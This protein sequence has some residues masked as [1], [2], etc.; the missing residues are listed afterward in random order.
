MMNQR[1][2]RT[3]PA[4]RRINAAF[5]QIATR[6]RGETHTDASLFGM[7]AH[8]I[9]QQPEFA[10]ALC[11]NIGHVMEEQTGEIDYVEIHVE[12]WRRTLFAPQSE[13][14]GPTIDLFAGDPAKAEQFAANLALVHGS[15]NIGTT[16]TWM[17]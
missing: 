5:Q 15:M 9:P 2:A 12:A 4:Q 6:L 8:I 1:A 17:N 11:A 7:I 14:G 3:T 13:H 16:S 10:A